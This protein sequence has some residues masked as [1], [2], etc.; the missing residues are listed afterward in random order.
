[1]AERQDKAR[2]DK[3]RLLKAHGFKLF[4]PE[5]PFLHFLEGLLC[6]QEVVIKIAN[7]ILLGQRK[8]AHNYSS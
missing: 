1:M 7:I 6:L 8:S 4:K 2:Q 5:I 3:T